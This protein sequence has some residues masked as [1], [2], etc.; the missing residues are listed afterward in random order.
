MQQCNSNDS[1]GATSSMQHN[2]V[3]LRSNANNNNAIL[4]QQ[5]HQE[6]IKQTIFAKIQGNG[7]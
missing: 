4:Q 7:G 1:F 5:Q 2:K 3:D 6:K